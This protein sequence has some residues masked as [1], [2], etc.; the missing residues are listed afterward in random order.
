MKTRQRLLATGAGLAI[1]AAILAGAVGAARA[2]GPGCNAY[3]RGEDYNSTVDIGGCHGS[4]TEL[5]IVFPVPVTV[6]KTYTLNGYGASRSGKAGQRNATSTVFKFASPA[7]P[8]N[9]EER[10]ASRRGLLELVRDHD[11]AGAPGGRAR[12]DHRRRHGRDE[13][14]L[15]HRRPRRPELISV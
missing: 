13:A 6:S 8:G 15:R 1:L 3:I 9:H 11:P 14:E 5:D 7:R 4:I 10:R 12:E 2:S